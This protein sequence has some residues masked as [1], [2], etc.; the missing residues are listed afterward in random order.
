MAGHLQSAP[1]P[2]TPSGAAAAER[3]IRVV[4]AE[5]HV[6]LRRSLRLLLDGEPDVDLV[7][8]AADLSTV[9]HQVHRH[10]PQVLVLDLQLHGGSSLEAIRQLRSRVPGA[11]IVVLSMEMSSVF[12]EQVL[13]AG[14]AGFV[15]KE[16]SD[17]DLP[18]AIRAA[19]RGEEFVSPPVRS[20]ASSR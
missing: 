19:V 12:A 14:A 15:L 11:A 13:E 18:A 5:D 16:R 3:P 9:L 6:A 7:A 1:A 10:A 2:D 8:D 20:G 4:L 17:S